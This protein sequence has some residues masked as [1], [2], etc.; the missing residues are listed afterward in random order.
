MNSNLELNYADFEKYYVVHGPN[1]G[2][3]QYI[4]RFD[5]DY[6]AS[7]L[8][9]PDFWGRNGG[10]KLWELAVIIFDDG[11]NYDLDYTTP[12]TDEVIQD[13]TDKEVCELLGRI[14]DLPKKQL[15]IDSLH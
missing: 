11:E 3:V 14:K 10:F 1:L 8:K 9:L 15:L 7:V 12:I 2:G 5:N 4:F 6:G 13:L